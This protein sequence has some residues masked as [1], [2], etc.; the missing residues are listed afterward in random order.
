[1]DTRTRA[2][3]FTWNNYTEDSI[4]I[5]EKLSKQVTYMI[6]GFEQ[7]PTTGTLH[8][9]GYI[10]FKNA[11]TYSQVKKLTSSEIH[12]EA[13]RSD[14]YTNM[15]Y[16]KKGGNFREYG[17]PPKPGKRVDLDDIKE[18]VTG[19]KSMVDIIP[20]IKNYQELKFAEGLMKYQKKP[21]TNFKQIRWYYGKSGS[22]KTYSAIQEAE[23][24]YGD[25]YISMKTLKWWDGYYGQKAVIIDDFRADFCTFHELLR[26]LDTYPYRVET[27]G[28]S[29]WLKAE[30]III[31]SCYHPKEVYSTR[32]DITQLTRR[33]HK[34]KIF[35][36]SIY[37]KYGLPQTQE[38]SSEISTETI[39]PSEPSSDEES[40]CL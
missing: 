9:Q 23:K 1:M 29:Q 17:T 21:Q 36:D 22:G 27:K 24:E 5:L 19:G 26:I 34:I 4:E 8:I 33:I 3:A 35:S 32:E 10:H 11:R 30:L 39:L 7:A 6:F 25:Y 38:L 37:N 20:L 18:A 12:I 28:G 40:S 31:T 14:A 2:F 15:Q 13:A 16:C